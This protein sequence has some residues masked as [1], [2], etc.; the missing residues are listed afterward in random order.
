M[1]LQTECLRIAQ[2][3]K[4]EYSHRCGPDQSSQIGID[5]RQVRTAH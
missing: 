1:D 5:G 4:D 3:G 2:F